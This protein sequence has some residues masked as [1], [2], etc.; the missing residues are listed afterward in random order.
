MF[1]LHNPLSPLSTQERI[2]MIKISMYTHRILPPRPFCRGGGTRNF[3]ALLKRVELVLFY[4]F[5]GGG[6]SLSHKGGDG[7]FQGVPEDFQLESLNR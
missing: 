5:L 4:F 6:G 1:Q 3:E 7:I 2:S